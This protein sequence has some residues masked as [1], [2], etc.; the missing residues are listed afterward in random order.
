MINICLL[1]PFTFLIS[2]FSFPFLSQLFFF[3]LC[4]RLRLV[5]FSPRTS[6]LS[7]CLTHSPPPPPLLACSPINQAGHRV[8]ALALCWIPV[9]CSLFL[10][11]TLTNTGLGLHSCGDLLFSAFQSN[12]QLLQASMIKLHFPLSALN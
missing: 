6:R 2:N 4:L 7:P 5:S 9:F 10:P 1:N 12:Y 3:F 11:G 8:S